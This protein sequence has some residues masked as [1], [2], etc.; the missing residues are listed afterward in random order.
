MASAT[1]KVDQKTNEFSGAWNPLD[2]VKEI[3]SQDQ[4]YLAYIEFAAAAESSTQH[5]YK[6]FKDEL[7]RA[8][9]KAES[10][11]S[12]DLATILER[13]SRWLDQWAKEEAN[14]VEFFA[15]AFEKIKNLKS[16]EQTLSTELTT[17]KVGYFGIESPIPSTQCWETTLFFLLFSEVASMLWYRNWAR[18]PTSRGLKLALKNIHRDEAEHYKFFLKTCCEII[19]SQPQLI[20]EAR[21]VLFSFARTFRKLNQSKNSP[22]NSPIKTQ[23]HKSQNWWEHK[24]LSHYEQSE[25]TYTQIYALQKYCFR[26][27][28]LAA[29][30]NRT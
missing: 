17:N 23:K 27:L 10:S 3:N 6:L 7:I 30:G 8:K 25:S 11:E 4:I 9:L 2:F 15:L 21:G 20:R 26:R 24:E 29:E 13:F 1:F 22:A 19:S 14:H 18:Q 5:A 12:S 16:D 28:T